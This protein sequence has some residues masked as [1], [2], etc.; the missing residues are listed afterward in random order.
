MI[1]S[2]LHSITDQ[3][4]VHSGCRRQLHEVNGHCDK[5]VAPLEFE[6]LCTS[7]QLN[8]RQLL[9]QPLSR[10]NRGQPQAGERRAS[11]TGQSSR[12]ELQHVPPHNIVILL[13]RHVQRLAQATGSSQRMGIELQELEAGR[14]TDGQD[15]GPAVAGLENRE[16]RRAIVGTPLVNSW[17]D[18]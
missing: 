11:A 2:F 1:T 13:L 17:I 15:R 18:K 9:S 4:T 16:Y 7:A 3:Y 10:T 12:Q 14:E 5:P 8:M 6:G